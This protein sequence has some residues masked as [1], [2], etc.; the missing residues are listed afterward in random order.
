MVGYESVGDILASQAEDRS[1]ATRVILN[2]VRDIVNLV[3]DRDPQVPWLVVLLE[4][5]DGDILLL[6]LHSW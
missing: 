5:L 4:L 3:L 6:R 1:V 2:P